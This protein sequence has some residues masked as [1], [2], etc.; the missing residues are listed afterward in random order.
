M[1]KVLLLQE[2]YLEVVVQ[3][4]LLQQEASLVVELSQLKLQSQQLEAFLVLSQQMLVNQLQEDYSVEQLSLMQI[5]QQV[6]WHLEE[7]N[8]HRLLLVNLVQLML[9][10]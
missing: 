2:A 5:S 3:S 4:L 7:L 1:T 6:V 10:L 8:Q 9:N